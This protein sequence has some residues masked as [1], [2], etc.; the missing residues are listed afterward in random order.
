MAGT[1]Q[2]YTMPIVLTVYGSER[3]RADADMIM[4]HAARLYTSECARSTPVCLELARHTHTQPPI[5]APPNH[6]RTLLIT[7]P[8]PCPPF[9]LLSLQGHPRTKRERQRRQRRRREGPLSH[10]GAVEGAGEAL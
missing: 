1:G 2:Q 5:H 6:P 8:L 4:M 3:A 10:R 9:I 7:P